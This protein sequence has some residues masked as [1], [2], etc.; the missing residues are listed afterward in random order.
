MLEGDVTQPL[1]GGHTVHFEASEWA[2]GKVVEGA[3]YCAVA[4]TEVV[5]IEIVSERWYS[6]E[7]QRVMVS[8]RKDPR[9]GETTHR[10]VDVELG[11]PDPALFEVP[12]D[13]TIE[14]EPARVMVHE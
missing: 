11:G 4:E 6:E 10:L 3:P 5:P 8:V 2:E 14:E 9:F 13:Y 12:P 1:L 7:L